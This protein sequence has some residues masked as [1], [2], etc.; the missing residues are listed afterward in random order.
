MDRASSALREPQSY[1]IVGSITRLK[2]SDGRLSACPVALCGTVIFANRCSKVSMAQP[3]LVGVYRR[4]SLAQSRSWINIPR[5]ICTSIT[6]RGRA[7]IL[8]DLRLLFPAG[9]RVLRLREFLGAFDAGFSC[10]RRGKEKEFDTGG[11]CHGIIE[12]YVGRVLPGRE[13]SSSLPESATT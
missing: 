10:H 2:A 1:Q 7:S 4:K 12:E 8:A 6:P 5:N 13:A 11:E 9:F 3:E